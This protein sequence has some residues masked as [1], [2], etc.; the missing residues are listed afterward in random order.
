MNAAKKFKFE[1]KGKK[2]I[3]VLSI[4]S[5]RRLI[6]CLLEFVWSLDLELKTFNSNQLQFKPNNKI[7]LGGMIEVVMNGNRPAV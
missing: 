4:N 7:N 2:L 5:A 1:G 6:C 3:N